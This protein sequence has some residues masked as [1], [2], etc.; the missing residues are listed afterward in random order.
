MKL[1]LTLLC[2]N[3]EDIIDSTI[4]FHLGQGVDFIIATDNGSTDRTPDILRRYEQQGV[5]HLIEEPE[6]NHDQATWVTR[7]SNIA[8]VDLCADWI[9]H[10]DADEFW[11]PGHD[12]LKHILSKAPE[13]FSFLSI[14]R[15]NFLP[16]TQ[17]S[18][19]STPFYQNQVI[20]EVESLN[21]LGAQLPP[22][23]C[24]RGHRGITIGDGNHSAWING[25]RVLTE[26]CSEIEILHYPVRSYQQFERKIREG[27]A[28]L[29][30]NT[31]VPAQVG[32]TWRYLY[33]E[34]LEKGRLNDYYNKLALSP[35]IILENLASGKL[36][37]DHR[38]QQ[39]FMDNHASRRD[40]FLK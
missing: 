10:S 21:H 26:P 13:D 25:S 20:R 24:H 2:R 5:L 15:Y 29:R 37:V 27:V 33:E 31:R 38:I 39:F 14:K 35:E 3:E 1:I 9:I 30:Q 36:V 8:T 28:A 7:M 11:L 18:S 16:P 23:V 19:T 4:A 40:S 34:Y 17:G 22:K 12:S 6:H 32:A